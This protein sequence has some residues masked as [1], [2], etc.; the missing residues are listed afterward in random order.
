LGL[1]F[2]LRP[3][4]EILT[5]SITDDTVT[6]TLKIYSVR[7]TAREIRYEKSGLRMMVWKLAFDPETET[8]PGYRLTPD[9]CWWFKSMTVWDDPEDFTPW[10]EHRL[11]HVLTPEEYTER[12]EWEGMQYRVGTAKTPMDS[13]GRVVDGPSPMSDY[14][15]RR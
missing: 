4:D 2:V 3:T 7:E 10:T 6:V 1:P 5:H 15:N 11:G 14:W 9:E 13:A 8:M 12:R